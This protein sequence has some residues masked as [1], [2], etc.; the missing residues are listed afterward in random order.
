METIVVV[1]VNDTSTAD[2]Q[3]FNTIKR[4]NSFYQA[5]GFPSGLGE[6]VTLR[7]NHDGTWIQRKEI[8]LASDLER[9]TTGSQ[10]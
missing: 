8:T 9:A 3:A 10:G 5:T 6:S 1:L 4:L 7:R 2:F